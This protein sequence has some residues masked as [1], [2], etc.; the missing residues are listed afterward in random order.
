[1]SLIDI[2]HLAGQ[3]VPDKK[4]KSSYQ[5]DQMFTFAQSR[6][7]TVSF[8]ENKGKKIVEYGVGN[9]F[10][11]ELLKLLDT[12]SLH[13]GIVY[14]KSYLIAGDEFLIDGIKAKDAT[15]TLPVNE[16]VKIN[17]FLNNLYDESLFDIK[18]KL[19]VDWTVSGSFALLITWA[20]NFSRIASI[21]YVPWNK[22][23][24]GVDDDGEV[25]RYI[26]SDKR[27]RV[28]DDD[29]YQPFDINS[30]IS[31]DGVDIEE[32]TENYDH[33]Q[34]LVVKNF[35]PGYEYYGRPVYSGALT[36]IKAYSELSFYYLKSLQ[37]GFTSNFMITMFDT[38]NN[39][40]EAVL[41]R[42]KFIQQFTNA[43]EGKKA[44]VLFAS[45]KE[46]AP[47]MQSFD[48][49]N[50]DQQLVNL[51]NQLQ[52]AIV[53][54]HGVTSP[55]LV[56]V[57]VP[58]QLGTG[59]FEEKWNLFN[60]SSLKSITQFSLLSLVVAFRSSIFFPYPTSISYIKF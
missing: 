44:G 31:D 3:R 28:K 39:P 47:V 49:K 34:I 20:E 51:Q 57:S 46:T 13:N 15:K 22:I 1:M 30:Q 33:E 42:Q 19:A 36:A 40:E 43:G 24:V 27:D 29:A 21:R 5:N 41:K 4:E 16:A 7:A 37:E 45:S 50:I 26:V 10:P 58:G 6:P 59:S 52:Y 60:R 55:E 23:T 35:W 11:E 38:I 56:G 14:T 48:T 9:K 53:S 17:Q 12:S 32:H 18:A 54:G 25:N 8:K 2:L